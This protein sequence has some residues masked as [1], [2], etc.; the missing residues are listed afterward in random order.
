[1]AGPYTTDSNGEYVVTFID[2]E[3]L[4]FDDSVSPVLLVVEVGDSMFQRRIATEDVDSELLFQI[5]YLPAIGTAEISHQP[6]R[7]RD[8]VSTFDLTISN[9]G[10]NPM[11]ITAV[12]VELWTYEQDCNSIDGHKEIDEVSKI[13]LVDA[14]T[15]LSTA[16]GDID[17]VDQVSTSSWNHDLCN[18]VLIS[19]PIDVDASESKRIRLDVVSNDIRAKF[20]EYARGR[21]PY[22][23][24]SGLV[25]KYQET[26]RLRKS[27]LR[28][29]SVKATV[30][31]SDQAVPGFAKGEF[32]ARSKIEPG[33]F[34]QDVEVLRP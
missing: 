12:T 4:D 31:I 5:D 11:R 20:S 18:T 27:D 17:I 7:S 10:D 3:S 16:L 24:D 23:D 9:S 25:R 26:P 21:G 15:G 29:Y 14:D 22:I 19:Q 30:T 6:L 33:T 34:P 32:T 8:S 2:F 1:M 13:L 28:Y